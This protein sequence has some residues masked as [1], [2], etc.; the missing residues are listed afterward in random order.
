[1]HEDQ[2]WTMGGSEDPRFVVGVEVNEE[3]GE[4]T[5]CRRPLVAGKGWLDLG[6]GE[7]EGS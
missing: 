6:N 5:D 2:R 1:M 4:V 3:A 7:R